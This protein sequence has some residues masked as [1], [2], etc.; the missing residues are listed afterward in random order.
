MKITYKQFFEHR[1]VP[2]SSLYFLVGKPYHLQNEVQFNIE[3]NLKAK[4]FD[5][6]TYLIDSDVNLDQIRSNFETLSLFNE[7][8]YLY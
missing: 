8:N 5:I 2:E 4:D 3:F 7:K 1:R 6:K